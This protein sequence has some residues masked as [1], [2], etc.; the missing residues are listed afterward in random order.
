[1]K[2]KQRMLLLLVGVLVLLGGVIFLLTN[3]TEDPDAKPDGYLPV[4][5]TR[6][7]IAAITIT[8][9]L[10]SYT[11]T[12]DD[13]LPAGY[14]CADIEGLPQ[15]LSL[16]TGVVDDCREIKASYRYE[17]ADLARYGLDDPRAEAAVTLADGSSYTV[18]VGSNAPSE[19]FCYFRVSTEPE[20]VY[21]ARQSQFSRYKDDVYGLVN[22]LLAPHTGSNR[23][24]NDETD[25]ADWFEFTVADGT[26]FRLERLPHGYVDGAG[27]YYHYEQTAPLQGYVL[28][29]AV[30]DKFYR[31]MQFCASS[32]VIYHPTE[33]Q[34]Q[35]CDLNDPLT[36][37]V[38]GY[39][40][41]TAVIRL[42][43]MQD[44]KNYY[45][46]K[47]GV[48]AIWVVADYM[49]SWLD[50]QPRTFVSA[51]V[52][53]PAAEDVA[54]LAVEAYG[55]SYSFTLANGSA[56]LNGAALDMDQFAAL[57][58]LACSVNSQSATDVMGGETVARI[59]FA[60]AAGGS[61]EVEL[62][63]AGARSLGIRVN[64]EALGLSIRES[65]AEALLAAC[66]AV[67]AGETVSTAW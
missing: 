60:L 18:W 24:G 23:S 43:L 2:K 31:L 16:Y 14:Y 1:M 21:A 36:E 49:V 6:D 39:G 44:G 40:E 65:Y 35:D 7:E 47:E 27:V 56:I 8:N 20:V 25:V 54:S 63:A 34:L 61:T 17:D 19:N 62:Y 66:R 45:A 10:G 13:A 11:F 22:R 15:L 57:Y 30:Q 42:S 64:G 48:D 32:A 4:S 53:A 67:E 5:H 50:I 58:K 59:R 28:G 38:I 26:R 55:E 52:A 33:Q 37:L 46:Y 51:Y 29:S 3:F 9:D 12:R 41:Q